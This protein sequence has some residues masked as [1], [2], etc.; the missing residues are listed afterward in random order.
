[1]WQ[2]A[3]LSL[4][5]QLLPAL[6][7][8]RVT[9]LMSTICLQKKKK[10]SIQQIVSANLSGHQIR[11]NGLWGAVLILFCTIEP[12]YDAFVLQFMQVES[13]RFILGLSLIMVCLGLVLVWSWSSV[14]CVLVVSWVF[15]KAS[16]TSH[17]LMWFLNL[18][19]ILTLNSPLLNV[20][21]VS[22]QVTCDSVESRDHQHEDGG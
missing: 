4:L 7:M 10:E 8:I 14:P 1:M 16:T 20:P 12:K 3:F 15:I 5:A 13:C 9:F 17:S 6:F 22:D 11:L 19:Y 18:W 2:C 21:G